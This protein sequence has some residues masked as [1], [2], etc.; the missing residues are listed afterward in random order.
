MKKEE[1]DILLSKYYD[2][3]TTEEE[4]RVLVELF[5][6]SDIP[7]GYE[8]EKAIFGYFLSSKDVPEPSIDYESRIF[9]SLDSSSEVNSTRS[10]KLMFGIAGIAAG[11]AILL[12]TWFFMRSNEPV[13][14][15]SDPRVA[16]AETMK[17]LMEVSEKM[18]AG[19]D[20]LNPVSKMNLPGA[21]GL[22]VLTT[23]RETLEKNLM[24]LEYVTKVI[25]LTEDIDENDN[26]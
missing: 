3:L 12:G 2:G 21:P 17:I 22:E 13:D 16:Y 20:A 25:G 24:N 9:S 1:L 11:V 10:R 14:T 26:N 6:G 18:N 7:E 4:E 19:A 8:A 5:S 23:S 15:F